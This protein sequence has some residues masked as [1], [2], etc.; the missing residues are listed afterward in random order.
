[1]MEQFGWTLDA[2]DALTFEQRD[3]VRR[4]WATVRIHTDAERFLVEWR[5]R[6]A[7]SNVDRLKAMFG[8]RQ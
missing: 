7:G 4:M 8:G 3:R 6:N 1:M 2:I 5:K